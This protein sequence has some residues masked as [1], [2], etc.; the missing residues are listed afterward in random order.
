MTTAKGI[1]A[2]NNWNEKPYFE[3]RPLKGAIAH[4][5]AVF[6]GDMVGQ[7]RTVYVLSYGEGDKTAHYAGHLLFRGTL[8]GKTGTFVLFETGGFG[9]DLVT[10]N[11][12]ILAGSGT[13]E[14]AG[15]TGSGSYAASHD[16]TVHYQ[17]DYD[18]K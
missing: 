15:I 7:A 12:Q 14:L 8:G 13:G 3:E 6:E 4:I 2:H 9:N 1:V 11:W 16:K 17:L 5:D 18:F 10:A